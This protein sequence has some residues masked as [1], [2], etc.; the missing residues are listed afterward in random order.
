MKIEKLFKKDIKRDIQGVVTIGNEEEFRKQQELEEYVCTKE[1]IDNF[2]TFFSSYRKSIQQPTDKMGVWITGFFGSGKSHF[3]KI[4]GYLLTNEEVNGKK[5][6]DYF[7][8]KISDQMILADIKTSANQNNLVVLFNI[9]S[10]AKADSK[11]KNQAIME[12]MLSAF[13]EKIGLSGSTPWLAQLERNLIKEG[14]YDKFKETF[15]EVSKKDWEV[16]RRTIFFERD[17]LIKVL[18][19]VK[20]ISEESARAYFDDAQKNYGINTETFAQIINEYCE[21]NNTRVI[22]L[23][24]E[25]GQFIGTNSDM[26]LNLQTVVE[27]LGKYAKGKAWVAVT[28]QQQIDALLEGTN[29]AAQID[30]S[31]IQGRFATRLMMSSSNADEVIKKRLLDKTDDAKKVLET[32]YEQYKDRLNNLL[33]FPSKPKWTGYTDVKQFVADYPFVNY[34]YELLQMTFTAIRE[35]GMSEGKHIAS[36]ERS[37]MN[38][39]Q[40]GAITKCD[41]EI[42]VLVPFN[43]FYATIEEFMDYDI[44]NVFVSARK[45]LDSDF[46]IEV[47]KVL[48][49]LKNV[50]E[51]EP[52]L[53]RLATLMVS[54]MNE[55]KKALKDKIK[56][57]LDRLIAET[58]A[59]QNGE[60]YEFLTNEEQDVNRRIKQSQYST[61]EILNKIRD[62]VYDSV[63]EMGNKFSYSKYSFGLNRYIDDNMPGS[64]NPDSLTVK[65]YTPWMKKDVDFTVESTANGSIVVDLTNGQYLEE[66]ITANRIQT[67]DRNNHSNATSSLLEILTRKNAEA[68]ERNKRAE[69]N[70]RTCLEDCDIY[71]NGTV[72]SLS[73]GD[74]KK[75]FN[76]ALEKSLL[77]KYFK[78][79]YVK[80]FANKNDDVSLVLREKT[81]MDGMDVTDPTV[82]GNGNAAKEILEK[83]KDD[84]QWSRKT[85][86]ST[87]NQKFTKSPFGY[88]PI[89]I[90]AIVAKLLVNNKVKCLLYDQVQNIN[91][92]TFIFEFSKGSQDEKMVIE[93]QGEIDQGTLIKVKKIM[94]DSFEINIEPKESSLK[95]E[96]TSF[97]K[98]KFDD[99][100]VIKRSNGGD[101]PGKNIIETV[102]PIFSKIANSNDSETIFNNVISNEDTLYNYGEKIDSVINFYNTDSS[103][104]KVWDEAKELISYYEENILFIPSLDTMESTINEMAEILKLEEPF[105][106]IPNLS[107][108]VAKGNEIKE[109]CTNDIISEAK[110]YIDE[111]LEEIKKETDEALKTTFN[112]SNTEL[113]I[114]DIYQQEVAVFGNL[115][116]ALTDSS[117]CGNAK[118]KAHNEVMQYK[119]ALAKIILEDADK[120]EDNKIVYNA[121]ISAID[122]VPVA[123][124]RI[125]T[126]EDIDK[127]ISNIKE[128]FEKLLDEKGPFEITK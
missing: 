60:R 6:A 116:S 70:I 43:E 104:K 111:K 56:E 30:F 63:V 59:Q 76:E 4:L 12:T 74:A 2:R 84:K 23:I 81:L 69:K 124:R 39:F 102:L 110:K 50:K 128:K 19:K 67:F 122:L 15:K 44:K 29:K 52:T 97:M 119:E 117:R 72:M 55:D 10:K 113:N 16:S 127:T 33:I 45:R 7:D 21:D 95:D 78:L 47:L 46:D 25:V 75:R 8:E 91:D 106:K 90:R 96:I 17:N 9:D 93:L 121:S 109:K 61:S 26:M 126:K 73:S 34:Q 37:L 71:L 57:S 5:A 54:S 14:L 83:I 58:F 101:Y 114:N 13:N 35:N 125:S 118:S 112:K 28:S 100:N 36:G 80:E 41:D 82:Y 108:L 31:K 48:F 42:G 3:L 40:K 18:V 99:L 85:T 32:T 68:E 123:N 51:M 65:I 66:L 98:T 92:Q 115:S 94:K 77:N 11:N 1:V 64:D 24:D 120:V 38:A 88:R 62:I 49:M 87:L 89:D 20:D 105:S 107:Q 79:S 22:F 27:D 53:E 86:I 103:Q